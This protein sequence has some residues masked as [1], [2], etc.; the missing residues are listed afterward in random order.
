MMPS[1]TIWFSLKR[2]LTAVNSANVSPV[3]TSIEYPSEGPDTSL[4]KPV[5]PVAPGT[6][7]T[8][9]DTFS[10]CSINLLA[11]R[12]SWSAPPPGPQGTMKVIGRAG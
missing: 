3:M 6:L 8:G 2:A 9:N 12:A 7:M 5:W 10:S 11:M 4:V 1:G